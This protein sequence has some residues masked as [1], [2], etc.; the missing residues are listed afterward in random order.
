VK[1]TYRLLVAATVSVAFGACILT[2]DMIL[3]SDEF[4]S[5]QFRVVDVSGEP[6]DSFAVTV[7]NARTG[8]V[9]S[10]RQPHSG[11]GVY[12]ALDD[13]FMDRIR[14][15]A[16]LIVHGERGD[17]EFD[18][19]FLMGVDEDGCHIQKVAGPDTVVVAR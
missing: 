12:H 14:G 2:D 19:S 5:V 17:R 10:V 11:E 16:P 1:N 3:C 4:V 6:Q 7:R 18:A 9:Y 13:G 8:E 15:I